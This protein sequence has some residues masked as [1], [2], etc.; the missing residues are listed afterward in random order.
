MSRIAIARYLPG[1]DEHAVHALIYV[2]AAW[3]EVPGH[4][5]WSL[6]AWRSMLTPAYRSWVARRDGRPVEG[7]S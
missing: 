1:E 4:T 3:G 2:D 5:Q 6:Q 7:V